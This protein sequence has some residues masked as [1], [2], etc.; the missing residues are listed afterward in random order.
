M[1]KQVICQKCHRLGSITLLFLCVLSVY[2]C[3]H[4]ETIPKNVIT[5]NVRALDN[6]LYYSI[7]SIDNGKKISI[8][9]YYPLE[10]PGCRCYDSFPIITF[11]FNDTALCLTAGL[12]DCPS[13]IIENTA[14]SLILISYYFPCYAEFL[15]TSKNYKKLQ[16]VVNNAKASLPSARFDSSGIIDSLRKANWVARFK[17]IYEQ[18]GVIL[19][20]GNFFFKVRFPEIEP[21]ERSVK[22]LSEIA[23]RRLPPFL[24]YSLKDYIEY[25]A[26][27]YNEWN[28][29]TLWYESFGVWGPRPQIDETLQRYNPFIP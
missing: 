19:K 12:K 13:K 17:K 9:C 15:E 20:A 8:N 21:K 1:P 18:D 22:E 6:C 11:E 4:S 3:H 23:K 14:D 25:F 26:P 10:P 27:P 24:I 28:D 5:E 7:D 2:G 16:H 29:Y